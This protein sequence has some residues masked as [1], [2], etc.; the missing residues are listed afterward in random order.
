VFIYDK[1]DE[2]K[3]Y[4][5][6]DFMDFVGGFFQDEK[7]NN[8]SQ[9]I[10][11]LKRTSN[12][13]QF[14]KSVQDI[15]LFFKREEGFPK[16]KL[17]DELDLFI[18]ESNVE[19]K[20]YQQAITKGKEIKNSETVSLEL[21]STFKRDLKPFQ[22]KSVAH[23]LAVNNAANFSVPGSGKT[24]ISYAAIS[25]W[26]EDKII[27]KI[28]VIGPLA[29]F[30]AWEKEFKE[31]F[32]RTPISERVNSTDFKHIEK[33]TNV[34]LFLISYQS[35]SAHYDEI[36]RFLS[37][38]K[39]VLILDESHRIKNPGVGKWVESMKILAPHATRRLILT[40]T[41]MPNDYRDLWTQITFLWPQVRPLGNQITYNQ[42]VL[43]Q[44]LKEEYRDT[45]FPLFTRVMKDDL[46][47][48]KF[49]FKK[50]GVRLLK[51]QR[52][53]YDV[54]EAQT[55]QEI[56]GLQEHAKLQKFR[57]AKM[58]RLL[59]TASNPTLLTEHSTS[60]NVSGKNFNS[61]DDYNRD[62]DDVDSSSS[63]ASGEFGFKISE[64]DNSDLRNLPISEK[65][66][67][68]SDLEIPAKI[69][70]AVALAEKLVKQN[71]KVVIWS[72]F[73]TNMG[74]F[75]DSVLKKYDPIIINGSVPKNPDIPNN[76]DEL[77]DIF[78]N[79]P[80]RKILIGTA[81]SIGES[82]SLHINDK[83]ESV[84]KHA[85]Y[86]D[87]NFNGAQFMQSVDRLHRVGMPNVEV[88]YHLLIA[89][90][91]IDER[92]DGRLFDKWDSMTKALDDPFLDA[93]DFDVTNQSQEEFDKD[94][95]A[96]VDE[97][98]KEPNKAEIEYDDE[99]D[100]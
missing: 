28:M 16:L 1:I 83:K 60:F 44:G 99:S 75:Q 50:H 95:Q 2:Q 8:D 41:P 85:I 64:I 48:P 78:L 5:L 82:V 15:I 34:E 39:T 32:H 10:Y 26:L 96:L 11:I 46:N 58:I 57:V 55:L 12:K 17:S 52:E 86:L 36:Q 43:K 9:L 70:Y 59:Q 66:S 49:K 65:I 77:I 69:S 13:V 21:G 80:S 94:Y 4:S 81:A 37:K 92:I 88:T 24:T 20:L 19:P 22:K 56:E 74:L 98:R 63:I 30:V 47:L 33:M 51:H 87:R 6:T 97:L 72:T 71:E 62:D 23:I 27:D 68:Y 79:D 84:C 31:C 53:I 45:L 76:R 25:K 14:I 54:I 7:I 42:Y 29:S 35:A 18:D 61:P 38:N 91:T 40:G 67:K 90:D 3:D 93:V 89:R 73:L 100:E